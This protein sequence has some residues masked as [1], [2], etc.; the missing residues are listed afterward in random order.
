MG[1][2]VREGLPCPFCGS[3]DNGS[4]YKNEDTEKG[5]YYF[6][7][8]CHGHRCAVRKRLPEGAILDDYYH[9]LSGKDKP[10]TD[11]TPH[12]T[13][14]LFGGQTM[15]LTDETHPW[16]NRKIGGEVCSY[17]N[18][19]VD[20][21]CPLTQSSAAIAVMASK[22]EPVRG[23]GLI[24]PYFD[25]AGNCIA[26]KVR[27]SVNKK[28]SW[29]KA[30][31]NALKRI[32]FFGQQLWKSDAI[33]DIIIT[34]GE[35][36]ALAT[37]QML[38]QPVVSVANGDGSAPAMF[39]SQY[40]WLNR[41]NNIILIPDNDD[42][43]RAIIPL[44]GGIF[45]RKIKVVNLVDYKDPNDYLKEGARDK[46]VAAYY[47][48]QP[49]TPEKIISLG[50]LSDLLFQDPPK[51]VATYPWDGLNNY[52]GGIWPGE[53][54][55]CKAPPKVG[56]CFAKGTPIRM[57][58]G[59]VKNIED[60]VLG[61]VVMGDDST[62]R[63]VDGL[64]QGVD[65]MYR[66]DQK[67]GMSYTVNSEHIL[68]LVHRNTGEKSE[69]AVKDYVKRKRNYKY[70]HQGYKVGW[71]PK[72]WDS[73][74]RRE[75]TP[76][77]LGAWLGD[78]TR[79][80]SII[81]TGDVEMEPS[82]IR[83]AENNNMELNKVGR[84]TYVFVGPRN[85]ETGSISVNPFK[86]ALR[87]EGVIRDK[88]IPEKYKRAALIDRMN[89]LAGI[90]DTDGYLHSSGR[91][92]EVVQRDERLARDIEELANSCGFS[93]RV[94]FVQRDRDYKKDGNISKTQY[95]RVFIR[96]DIHKIPTRLE[97]KQAPDTPRG[98]DIMRSELTVTYVGKDIYYGFT[99][100]DES[101]NRRFLLADGTVVHNTTFFT[102]IASHLYNT[103]DKPIGLIYL[104]ETQ[105]D[106]IFR[107]VSIKLNKNLQRI[108]ILEQVSKED[109][110]AAAKDITADDRIFVVDH[111]GSCSSD[112]I[113]EKIKEF[114]LAKG[115]QFIFFDHISMAI[116]D[117]SNKDERLALDRLVYAIK[118]LTVGIPD[119][120]TYLAEDGSYKTRIVTRQPTIFTIT[121]VNDN[122]QPRGSRVVLQASNLV[123][124][125]Q[126]DKMSDDQTV[127]NMLNVYVEENRRYG[128]T[129][130][131]CTLNYN[132]NTG[133]LTEV[134][135]TEGGNPND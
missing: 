90:I 57:F 25:D 91:N 59:T 1:I 130:R 125:L 95:Y 29:Y 109:L 102:E 18:V 117:E 122:G 21:E 65:D 107:F 103:T 115:C 129:G 43:C 12:V 132:T 44:L 23:P 99:V 20:L 97:R 40:S 104:E 126:R 35:L 70:L 80:N 61:D 16:G 52:T 26:Q 49:F 86:R 62:P 71:A 77:M 79:G 128:S 118:A 17:F 45:P 15:H 67:Y 53:L 119:E 112:F 46:F 34:F 14:L 37:Y 133:R 83:Y 78:G 11:T 6:Q 110:M 47:A 22:G 60:I 131:A 31:D 88:H 55:T 56:K 13:G 108:E 72:N 32:G 38:G 50:S 75:L 41:F 123:I 93:T 84:F 76:Y 105:R 9:I 92:F 111:W 87:E 81:T 127:K 74:N 24:L 121:H 120:E 48:A 96:G 42:S 116:S 66:V 68:S 106:L 124:G 101:P 135:V 4:I 85:E 89:L 69:I 8:N 28:G 3:K 82:F 113:E 2:L 100:A 7:F 54:I 114:V 64:A 33:K 51:P 63:R 5:G 58:D 39:K 98:F 134:P 10:L 73:V 19:T 30:D 36:D 27:T 94:T